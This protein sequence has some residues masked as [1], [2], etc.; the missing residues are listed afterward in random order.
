MRMNSLQAILR[1][2]VHGATVL[3]LG[4]GTAYAQQ[5][6]NLAAGPAPAFLPDGSA[7]PMW[8]YSCLPLTSGTSSATCAAA[9]PAAGGNWSPVIITVPTG[10]DLQINLTNN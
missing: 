4:V 7:V 9:N 3:L 8:G 1:K 5:Q 2:A 10:V 6:V